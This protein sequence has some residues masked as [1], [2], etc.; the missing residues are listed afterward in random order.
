MKEETVKI[1]PAFGPL[2]ASGI[3]VQ[4]QCPDRKCMAYRDKE[5]KWKDLFTNEFLPRVL[6]VLPA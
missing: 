3:P 4:V 2:P 6:G 5:G 1:N